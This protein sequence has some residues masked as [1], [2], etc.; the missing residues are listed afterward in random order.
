M[1]S[2]PEK[3][4]FNDTKLKEM[5]KRISIW[6]KMIKNSNGMFGLKSFY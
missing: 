2:V 3:D 6:S 4:Q 5:F 1:N